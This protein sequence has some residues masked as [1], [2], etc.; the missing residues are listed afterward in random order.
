M[1]KY[2]TVG[3]ATDDN[4]AHAHCMLDNLDHAHSIYVIFI[5]FVLQQWLQERPSVLRHTH[6]A[7]V[8]NLL[9]PAAKKKSKIRKYFPLLNMIIFFTRR[10]LNSSESLFIF[11]YLFVFPTKDAD[12]RC[13]K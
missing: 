5:A 9:P 4:T 13:Q 2:C 12:C 8:A 6:I 11:N 3:L 7:C 10:G 1:E